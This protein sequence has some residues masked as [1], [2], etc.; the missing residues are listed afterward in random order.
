MD[1]GI[2]IPLC[3]SVFIIPSGIPLPQWSWFW[4]CDLLWPL[5]SSKCHASSDLKSACTLG[6]ALCCCS[7]YSWP[8]REAQASLLDDESFMSHSPHQPA[9]SQP[10][11]QTCDMLAFISLLTKFKVSS[12]KIS[13]A[14]P[15][16]VEPVE[17]RCESTNKWLTCHHNRSEWFFLIQWKLT[18]TEPR[19]SC[20]RASLSGRIFP[21]VHKICKHSILCG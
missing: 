11:T 12:A 15:R 10:V 16:A 8:A 5:D 9:N 3:L 21:R 14:W 4:P 20:S 19:P 17:H 18:E 13:W 7:W 6:L 1:Y 2:W